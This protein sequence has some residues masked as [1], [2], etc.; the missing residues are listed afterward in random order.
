MQDWQIQFMLKRNPRKVAQLTAIWDSVFKMTN[1]MEWLGASG[2][3]MDQM[4]V[5]IEPHLPTGLAFSIRLT[6]DLRERVYDTPG[7]MDPLAFFALRTWARIASARL[8]RVPRLSKRL[9]RPGVR[10]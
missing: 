4:L 6:L 7:E 10:G 3:D 9:A 8:Q 2:S 1:R 5:N